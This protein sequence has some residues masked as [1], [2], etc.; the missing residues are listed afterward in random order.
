MF[1]NNFLL[2][3]ENMGEVKSVAM[4]INRNDPELQN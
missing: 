2:E 4:G 3:V 1:G